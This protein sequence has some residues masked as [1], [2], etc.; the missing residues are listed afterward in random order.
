MTLI[1]ILFFGTILTMLAVMALA[2]VV[3]GSLIIK[4]VRGDK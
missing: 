1:Q 3:I 2:V 4:A